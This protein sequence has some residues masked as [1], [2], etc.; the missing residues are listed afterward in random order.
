MVR[1][2]VAGW[3]EACGG[4]TLIGAKVDCVDEHKQTALSEAACAG[5]CEV[6]KLLLSHG[7]DPNTRSDVGRSPLWRAAFMGKADAAALLLAAGADPRVPS[8]TAELPKMVAPT[9]ELKE[10]IGSWDVARTDALLAELEARRGEQW[11]PPPPDPAEQQVGEAGYSIQIGLVR[12]ADALDAIVKDSD[13]YPLVVD[14]G[15]KATTFFQYRDCNMLCYARVP[16]I[17]P[18]TVRR[19][20]LGK[21]RLVEPQLPARESPPT[22]RRPPPPPPPPHPT[23][24]THTESPAPRAQARCATASRS[25]WT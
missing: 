20:V 16:D 7:A 21:R 4:A 11:V 22:R 14:L 24:H 15:G 8:E 13:R 25:C 18:E 1:T 2:I 6:C 19:A 5:E 17:E 23:P 10:A 3:V 9:P 12:L